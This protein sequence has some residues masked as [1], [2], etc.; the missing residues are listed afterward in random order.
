[1][2][3]TKYTNSQKLFLIS[4]IPLCAGGILLMYYY[5]N[6]SNTRSVKDLY[7]LLSLFFHIA[8]PLIYPAFTSNFTQRPFLLGLLTVLPFSLFSYS[9]AS[10]LHWADLDGIVLFIPS[11]YYIYIFF[12][13]VAAI[14]S[15][16][17]NQKILDDEQQ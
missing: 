16:R 14:F 12:G 17:K 8:W 1:M 4:I 15:D 7:V 3:N 10:Q 9:V 5:A 13:I 6:P 2:K 11:I